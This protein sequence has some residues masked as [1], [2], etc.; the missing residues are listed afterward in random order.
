M[1][2]HLV[3]GFFDFDSR[4]HILT[5]EILDSW[6]EAIKNQHRKN[7]EDLIQRLRIERLR[8]RRSRYWYC[9]PFSTVIRAVRY[10]LRRPPKLPLASSRYFFRRRWAAT[11]F[12]ARDTV[13]SP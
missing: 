13:S 12:V 3:P 11:L 6:D 9:Q 5:L 10:C 7:R 2:R 8:L 4:V 1:R